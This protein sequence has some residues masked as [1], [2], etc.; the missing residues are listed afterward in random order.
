MDEV[1]KS[2]QAVQT[3]TKVLLDFQARYPKDSLSRQIEVLKLKINGIGWRAMRRSFHE[4]DET[5]IKFNSLVLFFVEGLRG[6]TSPFAELWFE[7][8]AEDSKTSSSFKERGGY[9]YLHGFYLDY[10]DK[11]TGKIGFLCRQMSGD[12]GATFLFDDPKLHESILKKI[13]KTV[14]DIRKKTGGEFPLHFLK[15][16]KENQ[17]NVTLKEYLQARINASGMKASPAELWGMTCHHVP[18]LESKYSLDSQYLGENDPTLRRAIKLA[19]RLWPT[20]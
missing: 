18:Q 7:I 11:K 13:V 15:K 5:P 20:D 8:L 16:D 17:L 10:Q 4:E 19:I 9:F 3:L 12:D 14:E 1:G 2:Y 6:G